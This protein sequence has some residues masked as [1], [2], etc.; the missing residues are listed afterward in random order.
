MN[1]LVT[2]GSKGLRGQIK[3]EVMLHCH[4]FGLRRIQ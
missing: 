3:M 1:G 4:D 2:V